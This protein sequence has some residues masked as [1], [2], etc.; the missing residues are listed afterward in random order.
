MLVFGIVSQL[1]KAGTCPDYRF[2]FVSVRGFVDI[3]QLKGETSY[4]VDDMA[5]KAKF[6]ICIYIT[7]FVMTSSIS[8]LHL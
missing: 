1:C 6:H 7:C 2:G 4:H 8:I 3:V 5:L